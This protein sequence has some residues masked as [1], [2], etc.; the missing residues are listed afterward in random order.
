VENALSRYV[1]ESFKKFLDLDP[2]ADDFQ[3]LISI[4][5]CS[6]TDTSLLKSTLKDPISS[7][8]LASNAVKERW[9]PLL[10][11]ILSEYK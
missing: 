6:S 10:K 7:F 4:S 8:K 3:S 9:T 11:A 5:S 2:D 1:E